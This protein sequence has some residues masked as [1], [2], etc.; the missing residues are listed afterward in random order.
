MPAEQ[1]EA[2]ARM[3]GFGRE[4]DRPIF[5]LLDKQKVGENTHI[6]FTAQSREQ[7]REFD[8]ASI[9][10]RATDHGAPGIRNYHPNYYGAFV[11]DPDGINVEAVCHSPE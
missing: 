7:V 1:A 11:L 9:A 8:N 10:A 5:W 6:A 4:H 3:I 2:K